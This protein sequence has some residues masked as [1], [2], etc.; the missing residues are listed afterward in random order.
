MIAGSPSN[1]GRY[2]LGNDRWDR[3][4]LKMGFWTDEH[5]QERHRRREVNASVACANQRAAR[6]TGIVALVLP[7]AIRCRLQ[8]LAF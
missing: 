7:F 6:A 1:P 2:V 8:K 5:R 4:G 3:P